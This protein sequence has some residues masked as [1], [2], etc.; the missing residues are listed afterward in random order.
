MEHSS[1]LIGFAQLSLVLTGFVAVFVAFFSKERGSS[2]PD[3]HHALSMLIGSVLALLSALVPL[4]LDG[5]GLVGTDLWF[6]SSVAG[7]VLSSVYGV[8]MLNLTL[9]LSKEE[10]KQAGWLH[11]LVSYT[12]GFSAG[13]LML[14][15]VLSV[16]GPGHYILAMILTFMVALIG[17]VTFCVQNFL[18]LK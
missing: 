16:S 11:M 6:W 2:K 17:F 5:Y 18:T 7:L 14:W 3:V 15:N 1:T 12:L 8:M 9:R 10:F 4:V 13:G